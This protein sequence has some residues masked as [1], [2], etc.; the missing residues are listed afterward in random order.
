MQCGG[1]DLVGSIDVD[2]P[3][4]QL[5]GKLP[6]AVCNRLVECCISQAVS[7]LNVRIIVDQQFKGLVRAS[8][9]DM[10]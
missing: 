5:I 2:T 6:P 7:N 4:K 10:K 8:P 1:T 9:N 3:F